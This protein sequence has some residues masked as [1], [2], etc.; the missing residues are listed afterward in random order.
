VGIL[1]TAARA[2]RPRDSRQDAGATKTVLLFLLLKKKICNFE[3]QLSRNQ[4][5]PI[6]E[7]DD[8]ELV[9]YE[10]LDSGASL[11]FF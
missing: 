10:T 3:G 8:G 4:V 11:V 2:G 5:I 1:P 9:V 7:Y 6:A